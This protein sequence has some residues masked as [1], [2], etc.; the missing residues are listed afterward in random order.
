[1]LTRR[2]FIQSATLAGCSAA[3]HPLLSTVTFAEA[4]GDNRLVVII[5]RGA[6]DGLDV[7]RP[8]GDRAFAGMRPQLLRTAAGGEALD[9]FYALHPELSPLMPLWT[10]GELAFAHAVSTPYRDKRSHFDG[11]DILEAGTAPG[12]G[13]RDGWLNRLIQTLPGARAETAFSIGASRMPILAGPAPTS[14]WAPNADFGLSPQARQLL[15]AVYHDDPLFRAA[16]MQAMELGDTTVEPMAGGGG[17]GLKETRALAAY[18]ADRLKEETRIAAFSL[19][20]WDTHRNQEASLGAALNRLGAA[21]LAL[22]E[23]LGPVW[24]RTAVLAMTEFGRTVRENGSRGT[25]HGTGG[26][27]LMAGG[28]IRGGRVFG[29][30]PGLGES[31]LY[32]GRDLMPTADVRAYAGWA[33]R[34]LF[35]LSAGSLEGAV[36][37]GL[38]LPGDPGLLL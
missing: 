38:D 35:G 29:D 26:A 15:D 37:P 7:V 9:G 30:W 22:R 25:D 5:L 18:A 4:P 27:M 10:A 1:M 6:M 24:G 8:V 33:M 28:A 17:A 14:S 32:D 12:E 23:G 31:D 34:G 19:S 20:G 11:Q 16:A 2:L 13:A 21:I 36:F 3:A